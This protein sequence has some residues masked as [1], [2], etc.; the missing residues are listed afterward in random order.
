MSYYNLGDSFHWFVGR[1][2]DIKDEYFIGRVQIRIIHEQTGDLGKKKNYFGIE[3]DELLW[4]YPISAIQSASLSYMKINELE[5]DGEEFVPDWIGAVG[6]SPTG[7][8]VGTYVYG[9]YLDGNEANIPLIFGT[10]HKESVYPEPG[11]EPLKMLQDIPP[12]EPPELYSDISD[13]AKGYFKDPLGRLTTGEFSGAGQTLPKEPYE[14]GHLWDDDPKTIS[15]VDEMP[16]AYNTE[17]PYNTTYTTKRGHAIELDDT[18]GYERIH[19]WHR[20]GSYEE[21]STAPSNPAIDDDQFKEYPKEGPAGW[22]YVTAGGVT[23]VAWDGRRN[24]KTMD[25]FFDTVIKDRNELTQR[26]H[27]VQVA[28]TETGKIGN[29][30]H[31]T[32]GWQLPPENRVNDN[33]ITPYS[34]G[35]ID[36]YNAFYDVANNTVQ[37][38]GNNFVFQIGYDPKNERRLEFEY[39]DE[40]NYYFDIANNTIGTSANN[41]QLSVG[42]VKETERKLVDDGE[43]LYNY[44]LDVA[45]NSIRTS[46][47]NSV[48]SIGFNKDTERKLVKADEY[49]RYL[50]IANNQVQT[51]SNNYTLGIG[52]NKDTERKLVAADNFNSY[53]DVANNSIYNN[54]NNYM[55]E[56]GFTREQERKLNSDYFDVHNFY[57]DVSNNQITT[58]FNNIVTSVGYSYLSERKL[59]EED[60]FNYYLD[61]GNNIAI[62]SNNSYTL[63]V[64]LSRDNERKL[65]ADDIGN[66]YIDVVGNSALNTGFDILLN[67]GG[68]QVTNATGGIEHMTDNGSITLDSGNAI[69]LIASNGILVN[70]HTTFL[71]N[72]T[73]KSVTVQN[74]A[75][76]NFTTSDGKVVT[77]TAGIITDIS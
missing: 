54:A 57:L 59:T 14:V 7:I 16:T 2:V 26:D 35:G 28:N 33:G 9:F 31:W 37:T 21:I 25:S 61:V 56:V 17:Y 13:L 1:V 62:R 42:Y 4:A 58:T 45:N 55:L 38:T 32:V 46:G 51:T 10:Y 8:A 12:E 65:A 73:A 6:L 69:W 53:I 27:N 29:T 15:P 34:V 40:K 11:S 3:K 5:Y 18:K 68:K 63:N 64:G 23:E 77:V 49:N 72:I 41:Y 66:Y 19:I 30:Q 47:N 24:R 39:F 52:F 48:T 74:G 43:D 22:N 71:E 70:D 67:A 20:S 44:F 60:K 75:S 50:D 36:K 76:G